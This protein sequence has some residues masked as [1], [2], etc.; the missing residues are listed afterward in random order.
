MAVTLRMPPNQ[1]RKRETLPG[2]LL[3]L[4]CGS[5]MAALFLSVPQSIQRFENAPMQQ[6]TAQVTNIVYGM[7]TDGTPFRQVILEVNGRRA[8]TLTTAEVKPGDTVSLTYQM[9]RDGITV[10]DIAPLQETTAR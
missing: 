3:T 6:K 7:N 9:R 8:H 5:A 4:V 2:I 1:T 10:T